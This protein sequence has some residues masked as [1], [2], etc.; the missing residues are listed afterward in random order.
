MQTREG[1]IKMKQ[2]MIKRHGSE[3]AWKQYMREIASQ[4]GK[5]STTGGFWHTKYRLGD[6]WTVAEMGRKGG[7][8]SRRNRI[9]VVIKAETPPVDNLPV[10]TDLPPRPFFSSFWRRRG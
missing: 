2:A 3:E 8:K 1:A 4:G 5:N 9:P 10:S 6:T 7:L